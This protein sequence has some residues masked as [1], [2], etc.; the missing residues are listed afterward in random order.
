MDSCAAGLRSM[1][2]RDDSSLEYSD[3]SGP[4][5]YPEDAIDS[6]CL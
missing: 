1:G 3:D 4:T 5:R 6:D 2:G